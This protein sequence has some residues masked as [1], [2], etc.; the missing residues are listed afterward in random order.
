MNRTFATALLTTTVLLAAGPAAHAQ[1]FT[2]DFRIEDCRFSAEG[3]NAFF[4]LEPGHR[5]VLAG[6]DAGETAVVEITVLDRTTRPIIFTTERGKRMRVKA[7]IV[8]ERETLDGELVEISRNFFARCEQTGDVY[9]FGEDVDIYEDGQVVSHDGAWRAGQD[10]AQPGLIMPGSWLLGAR[11]FQEIAPDVA[12][13]RAEH[14]AM[15]LTLDL[16]F[17]TLHDCVQIDETSPL[18]PGAVSVK[19]YCPGVGL[20]ADG[21]VELTD[22]EP[23]DEDESEGDD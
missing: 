10:D 1:T 14:V 19:K 20:V 22:F 18:E 6:D 15:G 11:Y 2:T 17:G 5:L 3:G 21:D 23:G 12:L 8:V 9:Y 16:P 13:D 7:R 4:S